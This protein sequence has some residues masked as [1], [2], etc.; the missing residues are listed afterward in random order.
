MNGRPYPN[1]VLTGFMG[2]GKTSVGR[3]LA[4]RGPWC[5]V[6]T[7]TLLTERQGRSVATIFTDEGEK[8]FREYEAALCRELAEE[9]GLLITTGGGTLIQN[10]NIIALAKRALIIC[11]RARPETIARRLSEH[12]ES[13]PLFGQD[14]RA[15][16]AARQPQYDA[17][18]NQIATDERRPEQV[19]DEVW[20]LWSRLNPSI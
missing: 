20:H 1:L 5:W 16:L 9:A 6:D 4:T 17:L 13:R 10:G 14:W 12:D 7:D 2:T 19:A 18:P 3:I 15:L 8:R 11:L